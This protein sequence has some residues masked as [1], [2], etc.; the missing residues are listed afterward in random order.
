[1]KKLLSILLVSML[2]F[3]LAACSSEPTTNDEP[4][5]TGEDTPEVVTTASLVNENAALVNAMSTEGTWIIATLTDLTFEEELVLEGEF[6]NKDDES[7][8]LYRK[9]A[10]YAQDADHNV[11]ER[12]TLTAPKLTI[13]SENAKIQGGTI[14]GDVY[15]EA[16]GFT[17]TDATIE[18]NL[19]FATEEAKASFVTEKEATVTGE[20][21]VK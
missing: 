16:N 19:Y 2:I 20:T 17:L 18:G 1:M 9:L 21:A 3:S 11:T 4:K 14:V 12:Y 15:V 6:Y 5:E 8:G 7:K 13:K 10:L